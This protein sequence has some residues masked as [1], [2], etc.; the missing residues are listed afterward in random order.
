MNPL[1]SRNP[2]VGNYYRLNGKHFVKCI[3]FNPMKNYATCL[4][5]DGSELD[6]TYTNHF[7]KMDCVGLNRTE[8]LKFKKELRKCK[9]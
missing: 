1:K 7:Q 3:N 8:Y 2:V 6:L 9:N 5:Q 4:F